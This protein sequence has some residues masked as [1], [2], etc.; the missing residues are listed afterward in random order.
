MPFHFARSH[1]I[2]REGGAIG[3]DEMRDRLGWAARWRRRIMLGLLAA[4]LAAALGM[5]LVPVPLNLQASTAP[6]SSAIVYGSP[7][8]P[9]SLNPLRT[10]TDVG[11]LIDS[12]V[13]DGLLGVDAHNNLLPDL[14]TSWSSSKDGKTWIFHLR[15]GV[16]WADGPEFTSTDVYYTFLA[17]TNPTNTVA[18]TQ[19]W[20][21]ISSVRTPDRYTVVFHLRQLLAPWLREVGTTAILPKHVLFTR[22]D[23]NNGPFDTL[24]FGTGPYRVSQWLPGQ[25]ITLQSVTSSWHGRPRFHELVVR[26]FSDQARVLDALRSGAV[27]VA[28]LNPRQLPYAR[29]FAGIAVHSVPGTTWYHVDVKQW[30][31]LREQVVRQALDFATPKDQIFRQVL[32]GHGRLARADAAPSA[33]P[34]YNPSLPARPF[35]LLRAAELLASAGFAPGAH[36]ILQRCLPHCVQLKITLWSISGDYYGSAINEI[37]RQTWQQIGIAVALRQAPAGQIFGPTG[38]QFTHDATGITYAWTNGGDPDDRFY[39]NSAFIPRTQSA[40][41][42]NDVAFFYP[43]TFQ[44]QIDALT[45]QG[46][47]TTDPRKRIAV[48]YKIQS[49]LADQVPVIFLF[50]QDVIVA[51]PRALQGIEPSAYMPLFANIATWR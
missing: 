24:P 14:A 33:A 9:D 31:F 44:R 42:G 23:F 35:D 20:D 49:L 26:L 41:G 30:S 6:T 17:V 4:S 1:G 8:E 28:A 37:L 5:A 10:Q 36:G 51:A 38:P 39:W 21:Q 50:W 18:T 47:L 34:F 45:N 40:A 32:Q 27:Q 25:S 7:D 11:R 22:T 48:Y 46:V 3:P 16:R 15:H 43:F 2:G 13:F 29:Q 12:A 19:G